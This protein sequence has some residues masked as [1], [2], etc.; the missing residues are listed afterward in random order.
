MGP[1]QRLRADRASA[2]HSRERVEPVVLHFS[3][4]GDTIVSQSGAAD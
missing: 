4:H 2:A 3:G 1:A